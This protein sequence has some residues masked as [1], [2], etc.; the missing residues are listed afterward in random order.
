VNWLS[1][2]EGIATGLGV[3]LGAVIGV[4]F[5][6]KRKYAAV[7]ELAGMFSQTSGSTPPRSGE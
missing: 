7:L 3:V 6:L 2:G 1:Y 4:G 5:H